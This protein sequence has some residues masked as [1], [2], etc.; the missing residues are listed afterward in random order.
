MAA[1]LSL[2]PNER[3][4]LGEARRATLA[5]VSPDGTP[6][7][8][9]VCYAIQPQGAVLY[10]AIDDKPKRSADPHRLARVRDIAVDPRVT[11]LVDRW[12]EDWARLAW[13]RCHGRATFLEPGG[14]DESERRAAIAA[15]RERYPA[16]RQH[17]LEGSLVLR[18]EVD[19]T[20][21]WG[22]L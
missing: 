2:S 16:Y 10:V 1:Q 14:P 9:P 18:I 7:L 12:D 6:R 15:L 3:A 22:D 5:T 20:A 17:D 13:V 8:V 19:R 4:L 21:T 11:V